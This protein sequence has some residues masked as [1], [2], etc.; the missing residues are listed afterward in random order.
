MGLT[1]LGKLCAAGSA[2]LDCVQ[3]KR[4]KNRHMFSGA[5]AVSSPLIGRT[6]PPQHPQ[7][8]AVSPS[9]HSSRNFAPSPPSPPEKG[10]DVD[11]SASPSHPDSA[12]GGREPV[13]CDSRCLKGRFFEVKIA[14]FGW[15]WTPISSRWRSGSKA[16][17]GGRLMGSKACLIR[18]NVCVFFFFFFLF[19]C[20]V[21]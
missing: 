4:M 3:N 15:E 14:S 9:P 20:L 19:F 7:S 12:I 1:Q 13:S 2:V 18:G 5:H 8:K 21:C 11:A 6:H 17:Y 16:I 10:P